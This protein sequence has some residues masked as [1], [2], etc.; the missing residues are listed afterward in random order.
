V[1]CAHAKP[2]GGG[3]DGRYVGRR[4]PQ[5]PFNARVSAVPPGDP[6]GAGAQQ[7]VA[8]VWGAMGR[9][10]R[11]IWD[12]ARPVDRSQLPRAR[13]VHSGDELRRDHVLQQ[14]CHTGA[15]DGS[16]GWLLS[17]TGDPG[18]SSELAGERLGPRG[19]SHG[20][21]ADWRASGSLPRG[22]VS[23]RGQL[24]DASARPLRP[25]LDKERLGDVIH[26][27][28]HASLLVPLL[29][30]CTGPSGLA[31]ACPGRVHVPRHAALLGNA[32]VPLSDRFPGLVAGSGECGGGCWGRAVRRSHA[33]RY[34]WML[35]GRLR[36]G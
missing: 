13:R 7:A 23:P 28:P 17:R 18:L 30:S 15:P 27:D 3:A 6:C 20:D 11:R 9:G 4:R 21:R 32:E 12:G 10:A 19:T 33:R 26:L 25:Q 8:M 14:Q 22:R 1:G 36:C 31:I 5:S 2:L 35:S 16:G 34:R 24:L 29:R